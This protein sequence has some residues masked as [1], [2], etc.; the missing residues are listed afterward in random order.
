[1]EYIIQIEPHKT[2]DKTP[3]PASDKQAIAH[4]FDRAAKT[5]DSVALLQREIGHRLLERLNDIEHLELPIDEQLIKKNSFP[6][7]VLDLGGGT[8]FFSR[9]LNQKWETSHIFN[10]DISIEML[11]VAKQLN[12]NTDL[13]QAFSYLC[14][15]AEYLPIL[16]DSVDLIFSNCAFQWCYNYPRL[17]NELYRILKPKGILLFSSFGPDTLRELRESFDTID[18]ETHVNKFTDMHLIGDIMLGAK[19]SFPVMDRETILIT[20]PSV[21]DLMKDLKYMGAN[22]VHRKNNEGIMTRTKLNQ[23]FL[24][25]ERFRTQEG[26]IPASFEVIFGYGVKS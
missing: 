1:M 24:A 23:L 13:P 15:D 26:F 16:S 2:S 18:R 7:S 5:Y 22:Y 14:A 8:G 20:F 10:L 25:Y 21:K 11:T 12:T 6:S 17:F 19:F 4:A 3:D 9:V